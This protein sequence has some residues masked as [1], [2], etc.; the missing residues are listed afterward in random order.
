[1]PGTDFET[2]VV[3]AGILGLASARELL[4]RQP[5]LRLAVLEKEPVIASHQTGHNSGV[6]HSGLYYA[7]GS[8]K[9]EL[10][11]KG[12]AQLKT[13]CLE[14][15]IR[16]EECGK[17]VIAT[18]E[19]EL[20]RLAELFRRGT[21]NGVPGLRMVSASQIAD[22]EPNAIGVSAMVS[23][24]TAIVDYSRVARA[25]ADEVTSLG[26]Q[27]HAGAAVKTVR[28]E[29][30]QWVLGTTKGSFRTATLLTCAGLQADVLARMTGASDDPR[31]VP[32]R[33]DYLVL[34]PE[35][36]SLVRGLI[37]P[38]PNPAFPFLGIHAT[39]RIDGE[40]W[41]GPNAVLALAREGYRRSSIKPQDLASVLTWP[42]FWRMAARY[43]RTG[44]AEVYRDYSRRA[45][46]RDAQRYLP[47][48][49][50]EDTAPGP[51]G[52]RAQAVSRDGKL[53]DDFVF[54]QEEG[55]LHV[56]NA[57]SP[58]ATASLA[59][60]ERIVDRFRAAGQTP[61]PMG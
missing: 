49:R 54:S 6:I 50:L 34:K 22:I 28:R 33:G 40:V 29:A 19:T 47:A 44:S 26:A 12:A 16:V 23:P 43:W 4:R 60:A 36:R 37:Y 5:G 11:V 35:R 39:R 2:I 58:A 25:L 57:P 27:I 32:F 61:M 18:D 9:A 56:R 21:A 3:G 42:G 48:L 10:C 38:V 46:T 20:S 7:P 45:F 17:L 51:S 14:R 55:V 30:R 31:I 13:F 15:G 52:V 53:V 1:V 59:I 41:L 24:T 8:L